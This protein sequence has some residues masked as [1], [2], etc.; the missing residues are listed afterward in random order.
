MNKP[1]AEMRK[2]KDFLGELEIPSEALYGI[3]SCRARENFPD[4]TAFHKEWYEAIGLVKQA[5]SLIHI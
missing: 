5:L 2:E 4:K 1:N 3:H